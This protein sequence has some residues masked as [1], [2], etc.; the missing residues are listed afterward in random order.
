MKSHTEIYKFNKDTDIRE[1]RRFIILRLNEKGMGQAAIADVV[2]CSQGRVSQVVQS[3]AKL[4]YEGIA[5][6][7]HLGASAKL[8]KADKEQ[9]KE[10]LP[11]G[12]KHFGYVT[13]N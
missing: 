5:S 3:Y 13:D 1:Y 12:A 11:K 6:Q 9:L 8:S 10:L 7:T 4:G 2:G